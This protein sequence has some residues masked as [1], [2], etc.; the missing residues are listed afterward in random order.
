M[1]EPHLYRLSLFLGV[2]AAIVLMFSVVSRP[3]ALRSDAATDSFQAGQAA[4]LARELVKAAP[5]RRPGT[6]G[7]S[8]AAAF[9]IKRFRAIEGGEVTTQGFDG[10]FDGD[11]VS[12][13]NVTL[14][15]PGLTS[16]RLVIAAP[17]DC[18]GGQCGVSSAAATGSLLE[19]AD[20]FESMRHRKTLVLVSLDGSAAGAAGASQLASDLSAEPADA[21][22]VVTQ[23]GARSLGGPLVLPW[24]TGPQSASIQLTE[25]ARAAVGTELNAS[26]GLQ[27]STF[28]SLMRLAVPAGLGDQAPLVEAGVS[29][30]GL[31]SAGARPLP[32]SSD[33]I[34]NLSPKT[35]GGIGRSALSLAFAVDSASS[36]EHGPSAYIP[37][38]GK[39][40]PGWALAL[41]ALALLIPVGVVSL[42]AIVRA[43]RRG[44]HWVLALAWVLSRA[45]PFVAAMLLAYLFT[46]SGLIPDPAFPFDP[47]RNGIDVGGAAALVLM[48]GAF[49]VLVYYLHRLPLHDEGDD[50]VTP[51]IGTVIFVS[52]L[53]IWLA[54]PYL[55]LLLV[56]TAHLWLFA[57]VPEMRGRLALA[58]PIAAVGLILPLIAL[59]HLG[60]ELGTGVETPWQLLLMFTG[61]HFGPVA[62]VPLCL[63][64][65]CL[66]ALLE[67]AA[68]RRPP[69]QV[70]GADKRVRGPLTYAGP[71]SLGGTESA[72]PRR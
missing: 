70:Q 4:N 64:G 55:A 58:A 14:V 68:T 31:S 56:P 63:L 30:I 20:A 59:I 21:A 69:A 62:L 9:V 34:K 15:L 16:S 60:G 61:R 38:A 6:V 66:L 43:G 39:L 40:I 45:I 3:E 8:R 48:A 22:I 33:T 50:P 67:L 36:I 10:R 1:L 7:D 25:S 11:G 65:A 46:A 5:D 72:L 47:A 32:E 13:R 44:E 52:V 27:Q 49:A 23:P 28:G 51:A 54:N 57:S 42:D 12:L 2:A 53:G 37:L 41:L 29:A 26:D 71:G 18:A 19:L 35:L 17:R 24:S